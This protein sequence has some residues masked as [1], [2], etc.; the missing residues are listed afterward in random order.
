MIERK[1]YKNKIIHW[2]YERVILTYEITEE[3]KEKLLFA[4]TGQS[5]SKILKK[6]HKNFF[7]NVRCWKTIENERINQC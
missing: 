1:T 2:L 7:D 6:I 3:W 5:D 4:T